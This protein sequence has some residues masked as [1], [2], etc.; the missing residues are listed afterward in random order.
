MCDGFHI[1]DIFEVPLDTETKRY[2][3][4]IANDQSQLGADVIRIFTK[5]YTIDSEPVLED[6]VGDDVEFYAHVVI[7][8]GVRMQLWKRAGNVS[9]LGNGDMLFRDTDD[10]GV[11][12]GETP[13]EMSEDWYVWRINEPFQH[14]GRLSGRNREA[15][16]GIVISPV[17]IV[18][19]M[20]TGKYHFVYPGF[21]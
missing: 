21:E 3:Q 13:V 15:E 6:V 14:V 10:Y 4:Y 1:G 12:E 8:W 7:Q 11:K 17:H 9:D 16:I 5:V 19:R 18:D 20:R 2:F